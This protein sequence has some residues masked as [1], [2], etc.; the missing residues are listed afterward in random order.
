M[1]AAPYGAMAELAASL[2]GTVTRHQAARIGVSP[3]HIASALK[4]GW[5]REPVSG[6]LVVV[7]HPRTWKQ[8]LRVATCNAGSLPCASHRAAARLLRLDGFDEGLVELSVERPRRYRTQPPFPVVVHHVDSIPRQ[9]VVTID[10]VPCTGLARTLADLGSVVRHRTVWRA[11]ISARKQY[12]V[13][14]NWLHRTAVRLHRPGQHGTR[15]LLLALDKWAAEGQLPDSW[16]EELVREMLIR[17]DI[18]ELVRQHEILDETG[19]F[20]ARVDLAVPTAKFAIEAHSRQFHF[21]AEFGQADEDRD[22]RL[23]AEGWEV[24]YLGWYAQRR[25]REVADIMAK[26]CRRRLREV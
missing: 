16:F 1:S 3:D 12:K 20:V 4:D 18:P 14:A 25:P 9:D 2:H 24:A 23:G 13:N 15:A 10:N 19:R 7:G 8:D 11:L 26:I 6:V 17:P 22:L 21:E 5:L